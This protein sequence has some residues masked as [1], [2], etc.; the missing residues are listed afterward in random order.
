MPAVLRTFSLAA[1]G[2]LCAGTLIGWNFSRF[3]GAQEQIYSKDL[4]FLPTPEVAKLLCFGHSNTIS[5]LRWIDSFAYFQLQLDRRNDRLSGDGPG[6]FRRLYDTLI[7]LDPLFEP[8]YQHAALCTGGLLGQN[9]IALG[10]LL[11][12]LINLPHQTSLWRHAAAMLVAN[13]DL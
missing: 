9:Y 13:F 8:F 6:G 5:K 4:D 1:L 10:Y 11:R 2:L 12:G 3:V 7:E